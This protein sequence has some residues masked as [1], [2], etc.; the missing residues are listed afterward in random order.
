MERRG[1]LSLLGATVGGLFLPD[2]PKNIIVEPSKLK[3]PV[4]EKCDLVTLEGITRALQIEFEKEFERISIFKPVVN[5][6]LRIG[7]EGMK[8]QLNVAWGYQLGENKE[9][10]ERFIKPSALHFAEMAAQRNMN[11][12]GLLPMPVVGGMEA[13]RCTSD[14]S[15]IRCVMG[16]DIMRDECPIRFDLIGGRA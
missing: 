6:E 14:K 13:A 12:F 11:T 16:Y 5:K 9:V 2:L 15:S 10:M 8:H 3:V 7:Y 4:P 1:F